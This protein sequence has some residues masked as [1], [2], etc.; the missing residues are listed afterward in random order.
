[1]KKVTVKIASNVS[2]ETKAFIAEGFRSLYGAESV[3]VTD[4][5]VIGGFVA[6]YDGVVWDISLA[7]QLER[8]K[9]SIESGAK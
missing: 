5:S 3:F 4:D 9:K 2:E 6:S 7:T 1:M 8:M